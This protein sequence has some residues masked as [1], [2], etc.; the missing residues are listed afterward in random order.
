[1]S[2]PSKEYL[3]RIE[4]WLLGGLTLKHMNMTLVQKF[5]ARLTY[6]AYQVWMQNKQIR[7]ADLMRKLA[8]R[9]YAE[10]TERASQGDEE[11]RLY[12]DALAIKPDV[13]RTVSEISND[14]YVF[15]WLVG[16]FSTS[17]SHINRAKYQD[18]ADWLLR[19]GMQMG[20]KEGISA[21]DKGAEKLRVLENNFQEKENAADNMASLD[22]MITGDVSVIKSD[23]VNYTEEEKKKLAAKYHLTPTE[24]RDM[25]QNEDGIFE[26]VEDEQQD[27]FLEQEP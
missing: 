9:D 6:E 15:N 22:V 10:L 1:M 27:P 25:I 19:T 4:K 3:S 23:R 13:P 21:V 8:A 11:A 14:V 16:R 5:R 24:V 2:L 26:P 18:A 17:E 12:V 7:P 20:G